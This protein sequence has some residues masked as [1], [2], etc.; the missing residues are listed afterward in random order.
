MQGNPLLRSFKPRLA[1]LA[2][3]VAGFA[4]APTAAQADAVTND[5]CTVQILAQPPLNSPQFTF[6]CDFNVT[7]VEGTTSQDALLVPPALK[8]DSLEQGFL[9]LPPTSSEGSPFVCNGGPSNGGRGN[10]ATQDPCGEQ[11]GTPFRIN[12]ITLDN[13]TQPDVPPNPGSATETATVRNIQIQGCPGESGPGAASDTGGGG[14]PGAGDR[15][16][17]EDRCPEG[18]TR[19]SSSDGDS[20]TQHFNQERSTGEPEGEHSEST[21]SS[22]GGGFFCDFGKGK[23]KGG[24]E[25]G[26]GG[27]VQQ[28]A[29]AGG[30]GPPSL[31]MLGGSALLLVG[32]LGGGLT[33][34]RRL[35]G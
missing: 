15:T 23:P 25:S 26:F 27:E 34:A 19:R 30:D 21:T 29:I 17:A 1:I 22:D 11:S 32:V 16:A 28:A 35:N 24:V 10:F 18:S 9:C 20:S 5:G 33:L 14:E 3:L 4:I 8:G 7:H 12:S 6:N 2:V 31:L 13:R